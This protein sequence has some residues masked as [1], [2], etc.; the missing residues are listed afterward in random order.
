MGTALGYRIDPVG[1]S[2]RAKPGGGRR[3]MSRLSS[4]DAR[5]WDEVAGRVARAL[6][7]R[8]DPRVLADRAMISAVGWNLRGIREALDL[9]RDRGGGFLGLVLH[10]D[11][12]DFYGSVSPTVA[13]R[14][15]LDAGAASTDADLVGEMLEGW[16]AH[17]H[18]G[19][20]IG[21]AGSAVVA[22]A[23][24]LPVDACLG[25]RPWLR[26]VDDYRISVASEW[27]ATCLLDRLDAALGAVRLR[28]SIPKTLLAPAA[29]LPWPGSGYPR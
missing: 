23:V 28:R 21:P 22:N 9:A 5:T 6:E 12:E 26:W 18:Q 20:P 29:D 11:V 24:L 25:A 16:T 17:G 4:R 14:A 7:P 10:T 15:C 2:W 8:L 13:V 3:R 19:L 27:D 1:I